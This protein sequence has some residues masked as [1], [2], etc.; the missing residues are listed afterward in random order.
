VS[1]WLV[2]VSRYVRFAQGSGRT[3]ATTYDALRSGALSGRLTKVVC[4]V[5]G[6]LVNLRSGDTA[7]F[8]TPELEV[9]VFAV[10][11]ARAPTKTKRPT[12]TVALDKSRTKVF[13]ADPLPAAT[14]RRW[15]PEL[16]NGAVS[17]DLRP[18]ALAVLDGWQRE[19]AERDLELLT[20]IGALPWRT[21]AARGARRVQAA[22]HDITAPIATAFGITP[23]VHGRMISSRT[24]IAATS[25]ALDSG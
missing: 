12:V 2:P 19:R 8:Y 1:D 5:R 14:I 17:L 25:G 15:V 10:G 3:I 9:G 16:R 23:G 7:W 11:R 22:Q 18:R 4:D 24:R 13:A 21:A 6:P 20:P